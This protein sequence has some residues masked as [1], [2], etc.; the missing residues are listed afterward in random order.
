MDMSDSS[1]ILWQSG[2]VAAAATVIVGLLLYGVI[3]FVQCGNVSLSRSLLTSLSCSLI[4]VLGFAIPVAVSQLTCSFVAGIFAVLGVIV[5]V[6]LTFPVQ[7]A[8]FRLSPGAGLVVWVAY[9]IFTPLAVCWSAL[10]LGWF[11]FFQA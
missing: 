2:T 6:V 1:R 5:G 8:L 11:G 9:I 7:L 10:V 3:R 4:I